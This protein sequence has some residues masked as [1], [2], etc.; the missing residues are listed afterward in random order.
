MIPGKAINIM[1]FNGWDQKQQR[2]RMTFDKN[3]PFIVQHHLPLNPIGR[4]GITGRGL[5]PS[6]GPNHAVDPIVTRVKVRGF[7][8]YKSLFII[9][10]KS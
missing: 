4:T 7:N 10:L 1:P 8:C 9:I 6:W 2:N 3:A 5:L